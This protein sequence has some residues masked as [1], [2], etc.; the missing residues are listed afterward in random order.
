MQ[1]KGQATYQRDVETRDQA[2]VQEDICC[3]AGAQSISKR[4][5]TQRETIEPTSNPLAED[6][7]GYESAGSIEIKPESY[8]ISACAHAGTCFSTR[9][10]IECHTE[11]IDRKDSLQK[12]DLELQKRNNVT[13]LPP[14]CC[15]TRIQYRDLVQID[16]SCIGAVGFYRTLIKPDTELFVTSL[17]E[18][19][20]IIEEKE[21]EAIQAEAAREELANKELIEQKLLHQ[22][23]DFKDVFSKAASDILALY[24]E[25][26]LKI[27]LEE[28]PN[29]GFSLLHQHTLEELRACK[30]YLVENL[31]KG[32]IDSSQSLFAAPILFAR[33]AN[34]GLRFCVDYCKLNTVTCKDRYPILLL[35]K[36]LACISKAKI[37]TKLDIC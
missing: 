33:K 27:E 20:R 34:R 12:I 19:D 13:T 35:D 16:I 32:F 5:L 36:T 8:E 21:A 9:K 18:I 2:F 1:R 37:F 23:Y 25:Y 10:D 30:Q 24:C 26:N 22:Y 3:N 6:D 28:N 14:V 11:L 29:L 15:K 17:Y 4:I 7:S 31:S